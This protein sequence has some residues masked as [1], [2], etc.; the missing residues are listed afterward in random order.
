MGVIVVLA[1]AHAPKLSSR[2][3]MMEAVPDYSQFPFPGDSDHR[4]DAGELAD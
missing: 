2:Q 1:E 3:T 4:S